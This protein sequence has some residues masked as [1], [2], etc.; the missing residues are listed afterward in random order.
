MLISRTDIPE[1]CIDI[2]IR[3]DG[4]SLLIPSCEFIVC[5]IRFRC[6]RR[7]CSRILCRCTIRDIALRLNAPCP[8]IEAYGKGT[9]ARRKRGVHIPIFYDV[10]K[11]RRIALPTNHKRPSYKGI[12][13]RFR[14][15]FC[16]GTSAVGNRSPVCSRC[17]TKNGRPIIVVEIAY[18]ADVLI[19]DCDV[20]VFL[21]ECL[22]GCSGYG[23]DLNRSQQ[24]RLFFISAIL[25]KTAHR[26]KPRF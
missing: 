16:R 15:W 5:R 23:I 19:I 10:Q 11:R 13:F 4:S 2:Q 20:R 22:Y 9:D 17:C 26:I 24:L 8:H 18:A 3:F 12:S 21:P 6:I 1:L 25:I 14:C 7:C